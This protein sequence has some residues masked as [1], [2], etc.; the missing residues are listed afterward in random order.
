MFTADDNDGSD[1]GNG[2]TE[3]GSHAVSNPSW[4]IFIGGLIVSA[5][6][7]TVDQHGL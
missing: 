6:G 3:S 5:A 1:F 2:A 7:S 4:P